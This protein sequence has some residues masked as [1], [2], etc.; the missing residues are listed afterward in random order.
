M[1]AKD[2]FKVEQD[3]HI[4]WLTLNRPDNRNI[5]GFAF[6]EELTKHFERF[7]EDSSARGVVIKAEGKSFTVFLPFAPGTFHRPFGPAHSWQAG[8]THSGSAGFRPLDQRQ[9][10]QCKPEEIEGTKR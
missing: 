9:R 2:P 8:R 6:F 4:A 10:R 1:S 7:D 3:G 5:M